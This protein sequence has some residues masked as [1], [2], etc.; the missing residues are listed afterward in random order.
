ME[1]GNAITRR[2]FTALL[3]QALYLALLLAGCATMDARASKHSL[4]PQDHTFE[5]SSVGEIVSDISFEYGALE[6][7][8]KHAGK[9]GGVG[10]TQPMIVPEALTIKWTTVDGQTHESRVPIKSKVPADM[11]GKGVSVR[12]DGASLRVFLRTKDPAK[13]SLEFIRTQIYP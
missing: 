5:L 1:I 2:R 13:G 11:R 7:T 12:L 8:L 6:R 9:G 4:E 3:P 10:I